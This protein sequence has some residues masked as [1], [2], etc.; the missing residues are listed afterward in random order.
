[1]G[2]SRGLGRTAGGGM[3]GSTHLVM[4]IQWPCT[5]WTVMGRG[6][7]GTTRQGLTAACHQDCE[8]MI[9]RAALTWQA[10]GGLLGVA[11]RHLVAIRMSR[12]RPPPLLQAMTGMRTG[13]V[14]VHAVQQVNCQCNADG[15][16]GEVQGVSYH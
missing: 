5:T 14:A 3:M 6:V 16:D 11:Q 12:R 10:K 2:E 4:Q 7:H 13:R 15:N 1:V 9:S 8:A